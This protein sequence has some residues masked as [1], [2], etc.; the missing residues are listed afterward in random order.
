MC[1]VLILV[2]GYV[3]VARKILIVQCSKSESLKSRLI[4]HFI[5]TFQLAK[6]H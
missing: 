4:S 2:D 3:T 5:S 1:A 6:Y